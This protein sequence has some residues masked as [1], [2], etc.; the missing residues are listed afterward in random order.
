M[1]RLTGDAVT[2]IGLVAIVGLFFALA[3]PFLPYTA[4]DAYIT[5]R[6]SRHW[7][8]GVGPYFNPGEHAAHVEGYSNFLLMS[9][10]TPII[11]FGGADAALPAAKTIG[12]VAAAA[13]LIGSFFTG[14][15][16]SL[17]SKS[18]QPIANFAGLASAGLVACA[19]GFAVNAACGPRDH[20]L[21]VLRDMGRVRNGDGVSEGAPVGLAGSRCGSHHPTRGTRHL[22]DRMD[23]G[24]RAREVAAGIVA[25][26]W[27]E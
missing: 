19:P 24:G 14:R 9:L 22:C 11:R 2:A 27:R 7:A 4:D 18:T 5:F 20:A 17:A 10:L 12:L 15:S 21:R 1:R 13:G 8:F 6:Y 25:A 26:A 3:A 16:L 23:A